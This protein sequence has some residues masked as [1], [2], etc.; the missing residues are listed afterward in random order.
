M[1][2]FRGG[3]ERG[4]LPAYLATFGIAIRL[5]YRTADVEVEVESLETAGRS[6]PDD[7]R[8]ALHSPGGVRGPHVHRIV[9]AKAQQGHVEIVQVIGLE[10]KRSSGHRKLI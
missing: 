7:C 9:G 6:E 10:E 8:R 3:S 4:T 5:H 2:A 1:S